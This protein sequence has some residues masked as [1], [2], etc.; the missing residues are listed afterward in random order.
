MKCHSIVIRNNWSWQ[1]QKVNVGVGP[2]VFYKGCIEPP[3]SPDK[4]NIGNDL[5]TI[6]EN[7]KEVD[8]RF[9]DSL[10]HIREAT[11]TK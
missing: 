2:A 5:I 6:F 9:L 1:L 11:F 4:S 7:A 10:A 8:D 3:E